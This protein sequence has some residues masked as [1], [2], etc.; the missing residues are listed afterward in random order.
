MPA[1][2]QTGGANDKV[3]FA[4]IGIGAW[5]L[6][7][8]PRRLRQR[9]RSWSP[10]PTS[11]MAGSG[12]PGTLRQRLTTTRDYKEILARK[13]IDAVIVATPDH[14]HAQIAIEAMEAGKDVYVKNP[15]CRSPRTG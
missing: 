13:D 10:W 7:I 5:A 4:T 12:A 1:P 9:A 2:G 8:L 15:W 3:Q 6:E 14:W 11:M